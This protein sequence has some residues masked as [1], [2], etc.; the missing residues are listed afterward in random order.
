LLLLNFL[1][2]GTCQG[3]QLL[4]I[5]T[6]DNET[7]DERYQYDS[8]NLPLPLDFTPNAKS[9][10]MFKNA[11]QHIFETFRDKSITMNLHHD[12]GKFPNVVKKISNN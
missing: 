9:S 11:P 10:R 5:L 6:A 8:E 7:V 2:W 4:S 12:G 1:V 3:F